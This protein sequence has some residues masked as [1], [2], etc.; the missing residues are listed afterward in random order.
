MGYRT[1]KVEFNGKTRSIIEIDPIEAEW[2]KYI[3]KRFAQGVKY[4]ILI[5]ELHQMGAKPRRG[6]N[7]TKTSFYSILTNPIYIGKMAWN[8]RPSKS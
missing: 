3:F 1:K 7:F 5:E 6:E 2:V 4:S 8:K